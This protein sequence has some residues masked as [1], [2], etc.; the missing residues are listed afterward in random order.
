MRKTDSVGVAGRSGRLR[1][2]LPADA[3]VPAGFGT[4]PARQC[5][6]S[7]CPGIKGPVPPPVSMDAG[8][9]GMPR[10]YVNLFIRIERF[11]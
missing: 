11:K 4:S 8:S 7:G 3:Q 9:L 2:H 1:N 10:G 5:A 6:P